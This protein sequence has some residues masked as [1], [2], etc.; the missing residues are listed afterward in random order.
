MHIELVRQINELPI[1]E[2]VEIIEQVSRGVR[3]DMK[4]SGD[5][6]T[7]EEKKKTSERSYPET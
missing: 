3:R 4:N 2:R 5:E 1:T 6:I 7:A